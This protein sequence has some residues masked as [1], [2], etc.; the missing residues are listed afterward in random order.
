M[1]T[2]NFEG[3]ISSRYQ[4][5]STWATPG[6]QMA[7]AYMPANQLLY[8]GAT[9][10]DVYSWRVRDRKMVSTLAGH[11]DICMSL[12]ILKRLNYLASASL[13]TTV[14]V[15][16]SYTNDRL[17][18]LHGHK[19]GIL[20]LT[21]SP[22]F[23]LLVSCGFEH[24]ALV[25]SPFVKN[26]V[27]R[28]KGH[29]FAL[30]GVRAVE[31]T[32]E[33][34]TADVSG[35]FKLWDVRKFDCVQTFQ[36]NLSGTDTK[37]N[38]RL[39]CF[40]YCKLRSRNAMQKEDDSRIY[41][42]S[43]QVMSFDQER[44]V[45]AATTDK[46]TVHKIFWVAEAVSFITVSELNVI[47]WDALIGSKTVSNDAMNGDVEITACCLDDRKRK[48]VVGDANGHINV[49][50]HQN[51]QMM[52][53][54]SGRRNASAVISLVYI[55]ETIRFIA[56]YENGLIRVFDENPIEDC[57][58]L[59]TFD[60]FKMHTELC[61]LRYD[62]SLDTMLTAGSNDGIIRIW[63]YSAAKCEHEHYVAGQHD[64]VIFADF[65]SP[66]PIIVTSDSQNNIVLWGSRGS[67]F[68][69]PGR[70]AGFMNQTPASASLEPHIRSEG[71]EES[72]PRRSMAGTVP[73]AVVEAEDVLMAQPQEDAYLFKNEPADDATLQAS[74]QQAM[75][76][77]DCARDKWGESTAAQSIAWDPIT[78][79]L[80][81]C[82]DLGV[83]R[84]FNVKKVIADIGMDEAAAG[85]KYPGELDSGDGR[86][87]EDGEEEKGDSASTGSLGMDG[88]GM[89]ALGD[90]QQDDEDDSK[91][92]IGRRYVKGIARRLTRTARSALP[93]VPIFKNATATVA[94]RTVFAVAEPND[95][96]AYQGVD[97]C[98]A[99]QA[100]GDRIASCVVTKH[101]CVTSGADLLVKMWTYD[102]MP[103]GVLLQSVPVTKRSQTW[104]LVLDAEAIMK[105][106]DEELDDIIGEVQDL[107]DDPDKPDI[108]NMDFAAMEPGAGAEEFTRSELR[109]RIDE[110]SNKLGINF[111]TEGEEIVKVMGET[112]PDDPDI[113]S[114]DSMGRVK[115]LDNALTELRSYHSASEYKPKG[116]DKTEMQ[117]KM[118][119]KKYRQIARK[120]E[121]RGGML[122]GP[123]GSDSGVINHDIEEEEE[124]QISP[125]D[126]GDSNAP[127]KT[128]VKAE[129]SLAES[130]VDFTDLASLASSLGLPGSVKNVGDSLSQSI[131]KAAQKGKR[132][133]VIKEKCNR[134]KGW[135]ALEEALTTDA[136]A[137]K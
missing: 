137:K 27:Y 46:T 48:M 113:G 59:R 77:I 83:L 9:N 22:E 67:Y 91:D 87:D 36:A 76:A 55:T 47:V 5:T 97:F 62:E 124:V 68:K 80:F 102:G 130:S 11:T 104:D 88:M 53:T 100:H 122:V 57:N 3:S 43:K 1:A 60:P 45:H 105:R 72:R 81:A 33:L 75:E 115:T 10:G 66:L 74:A 73:D 23:R 106:E 16:D 118:E 116:P 58:V 7:M 89:T 13:D 24:D 125:E 135:A 111:P 50:N 99:L 15:W 129:A 108:H 126:G 30:C 119:L 63:D 54:S 21:Y 51:G 98:W 18:H 82:D 79:T 84:C 35:V 2:Y 38:S 78:C 136:S 29:H 71:N 90:K 128:G 121:K 117:L 69:G 114:I 65:L 101:G 12:C 41:A 95:A 92:N 31:N 64:S 4:P 19:K 127:P 86:E 32:P 123:P 93:P 39:S 20:D 52:K 110:T 134:Y 28:L 37:D 94:Q 85:A 109:Q 61:S 44:V 40:E 120:F 42:A 103:L 6:V 112:D 133:Q 56:G 34:I 8:S 49:Y 132:T 26:L 96:Y 107:V 25:W 70:I 14:S 131:A 17:L